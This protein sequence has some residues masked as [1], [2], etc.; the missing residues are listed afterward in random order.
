VKKEKEDKGPG[1]FWWIFT[2]VIL[3]GIGFWIFSKIRVY[4]ANELDILYTEANN[5]SYAQGVADAELET[6]KFVQD[7][8]KGKDD[9]T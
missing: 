4:G 1:I 6:N 9:L 8:L 5:P 2:P 7:F 3:L